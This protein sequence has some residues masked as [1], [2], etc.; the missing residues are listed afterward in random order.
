MPAKPEPSIADLSAAY[1][2]KPGPFFQRFDSIVKYTAYNSP[3]DP[4][5]HDERFSLVRTAARLGDVPAIEFFAKGLD[6]KRGYDFDSTSALHMAVDLKWP[7]C[8]SYFVA[9]GADPLR[10]DSKGQTA[11]A[12]AQSKWEAATNLEDMKIF[13][14]LEVILLSAELS[15]PQYK[16][17]ENFDSIKFPSPTDDRTPP[18]SQSTGL[19]GLLQRAK[20]GVARLIS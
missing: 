7:E 12:S 10:K 8:A 4:A 9:I 2:R 15:Y 18:Q 6:L 19:A 17:P 20:T 3:S 5:F 16:P 13:G 1:I 14:H 11:R